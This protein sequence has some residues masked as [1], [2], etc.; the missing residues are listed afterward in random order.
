MRML[1][2]LVVMNFVIVVIHSAAH[3]ALGIVPGFADSAFIIAVIVVGPL[4]PLRFLPS[5]SRSSV[6]ALAALLLASFVYGV[7][8][9]FILA[10]AD[11]IA[12]DPSSPWTLV[13][14]A[15]AILLAALEPAGAAIAVVVAWRAFRTPSAPS[16]RPT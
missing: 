1:A 3:F 9:H 8:N 11:H 16:G 14:V 4:I 15:T 2:I 12:I 6:V 5:G 13:F 10:G 7:S